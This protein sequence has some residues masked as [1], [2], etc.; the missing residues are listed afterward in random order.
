MRK[1]K[2]S[3]LK[4]RFYFVAA[5]YFRWFANFS[6][7]R[8]Q[9]RVIAVTG[10]V[11]KTTMLN[12][13]EVQLKNKAHYSHNA[14]SAFGIAFDILGMTGIT[15][16]KWRWLYLFLVAPIKALY[17][18]RKEKFYV[19]EIDGERPRETEFLAKWL[20]PEATLWVSLGKSH[21]C[22]FDQQVKNGEFENLDKA[23]AHEFAMLP[24]HTKKIIIIN[25][26]VPLIVK[27]T[28]KVK[29]KHKTAAEIVVCKKPENLSYK[30]R[31]EETH[32]KYGK[33]DFKFNQPMPKEVAI[34]LVMME[35]LMLYLKMELRTDLATFV[36][37]P[38]RSS[39]FDG[40][41]GLRLVDSSYNAHLISMK[42]ILE[43]AKEMEAKEKWLVIGDIVDQGSIES[44]EHKKLAEE[45]MKVGAKKVI[46]VG[47]RTK[48]YTY[49][50]LKKTEVE[51]V[52]VLEPKAALNII[53]D[54]AVNG[55]TIILKGSQYL[56]WIVEKLLKNPEEA[57]LLPR[58]EK[59]A[60]KRRARRGLI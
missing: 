17:Y 39:Y 14:N 34:Q 59:A 23:I 16:T 32:F 9:P 5:G 2:I 57:K 7:K 20:K 47:R 28:N 58:R 38:G 52:S 21:A 35:E 54:E 12:L 29:E 22:Q 43:M 56:E 42:S 10:S 53:L 27:A 50:I 4:K 31:P 15:N 36:S 41:G 48:K 24:E 6:L 1:P 60:I 13:L 25:A 19:V 37:P 51:V 30:V 33:H 45:I 55:Q 11:G 46:L 40:K 44:E 3:N 26:E 49:P 18:R 8:W